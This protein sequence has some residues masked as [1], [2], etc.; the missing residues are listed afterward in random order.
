MARGAGAQMKMAAYGTPDE[1][2]A[3]NDAL[4]RFMV[5]T[6]QAVSVSPEDA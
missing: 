3:W 1:A 6:A 2:P 4:I 5:T